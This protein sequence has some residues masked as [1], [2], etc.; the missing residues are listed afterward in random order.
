MPGLAFRDVHKSFGALRALG[1]VSF[2]VEPGETHACVGENGAGKS[3]LLKILAGI[4]RPDR[5]EITWRGGPLRFASPRDALA[6]GI[7]IVYQER[8]YF[9]NL[10][11]AANVFAGHEIVDRIGRLDE[12][13]MRARAAA[14]LDGLHIPVSPDVS[15]DRL[16]PAHVQL[17]QVA[18]AIA[19]D[20]QVLVLDEPTTSLTDAEVAHLF[21]VLAALKARGVTILFVSHRLPEVFRLC[22]QITV[23]RDGQ[24]VAT[25]D[26]RDA[27]VDQVVR[28]MVGRE[29]PDRVSRDVQG[30]GAE[31]ALSVRGVARRPRVADVSLEVR[32]GEIVGLFGLVGS[33]R[34]ELLETIFG[35]ARPDRGVIHVHG[36]PLAAGDPAAAVAAGVALVPEDRQQQG[37]FYNL[38]LRDNLMIAGAA[39]AS[40]RPIDRRDEGDRAQAQVSA[41]SIKVPGLGA[42]PD[43]LSGG[44]QQKIVVG[45]WL[46][47][48]PRLLL[49]D[50]PTKGVDVGAK[51]ELHNII[52]REAARGMACLVASSDLPEV[53]ALADRILIMRDGRI[54]GEV[55]GE[56]ATEARVMHLA[57][58][59]ETPA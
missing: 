35:L 45:K 43:R 27:T 57:A 9:P 24:Y 34:S 44:N 19:F 17:V 41:L 2:A 39:R 26:R 18:R 11:V 49:L 51:Y 37:L 33:G 50:E 14:L 46:A 3:T 54:Q 29:P 12:R 25:F 20:C 16:S 30:L 1:G 40:G 31:P 59:E 56:A 47:T 28:A 22:D 42:T 7:G 6:A 52:R 55:S 5:G 15:M 32:P 8:L 13:A 38:S 36:R 21:A 10:S 48:A 58:H 23:L 4:L 53:L